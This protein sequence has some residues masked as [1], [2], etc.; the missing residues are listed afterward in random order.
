MKRL[1]MLALA[2][3][4]ASCS[5]LYDSADY[6]G[7]ARCTTNASC[8][9]LGEG[10]VCDTDANVC[11]DC[12]ADDDGALVSSM[13]RPAC[14]PSGLADCDDDD[15][16]RHPG[17]VPICGNDH[18]ETCPDPRLADFAGVVEFEEIGF[19]GYRVPAVTLPDIRNFAL[20][21]VPPGVGYHVAVAAVHGDGEATFAAIDL[22]D[23]TRR[24]ERDLRMFSATGSLPFTSIEQVALEPFLTPDPDMQGAILV[25]GGLDTASTWRVTGGAVI[26]DSE[27]PLAGLISRSDASAFRP[28]AVGNGMSGPSGVYRSSTS[29]ITS[30]DIFNR[31]VSFASAAIPDGDDLALVSSGGP[32]VL[33]ERAATGSSLYLWDVA[34][35]DPTVVPPNIDTPSRVGRPAIALGRMEIDPGGTTLVPP[36]TFVAGWYEEVGTMKRLV[37]VPIT[38]TGWT[39][40]TCTIG[41]ENPIE[42]PLGLRHVAMSGPFLIPTVALEGTGADAR[43]TLRLINGATDPTDMTAPPVGSLLPGAYLEIARESELGGSVA[44]LDVSSWFDLTTGGLVV[45]VAALVTGAEDTIPVTTLHVC[46]PPDVRPMP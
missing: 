38:C 16:N 17:A 26:L 12:D 42:T 35:T 21:A 10:F 11:V 3:P 46:F 18:V 30:V 13:I 7:G 20:T 6:T 1:A 27:T 25:V 15:P 22:T 29:R 44:D 23:P 33:G 19:V 45:A 41:A 14:Q 40:D 24:L 4:I 37:V 31:E 32:L 8:A 36:S 28:F 9:V 43:I 39:M 34:T 2:A 5:F